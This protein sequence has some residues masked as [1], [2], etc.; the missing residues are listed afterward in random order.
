MR[1]RSAAFLSVLLLRPLL[2]AAT[3]AVGPRPYF[4]TFEQTF[5]IE[6][7][8]SSDARAARLK[9]LPLLNGKEWAVTCRWD[10][11]SLSGGLPMRDEMEKHGMKGSFYLNGPEKRA[12]GWDTDKAA[13]LL[14]GGNSLGGHGWTHAYAGWLSRHAMFE[15]LALPKLYWESVT[16]TPVCSHAFAYGN[17][18]NSFD[19]DGSARDVDE[20]LFRVGFYEF[21]GTR[22]S[23]RN[24]PSS[25]IIDPAD[26][27]GEPE[28]RQKNIETLKADKALQESNPCMTFGVHAW[29]FYG[30]TEKAGRSFALVENGL[31]YWFCNQ[32]E[33]GAYRLQYVNTEFKTEISGSAL[34][35]I[36]KRPALF[37]LMHNIPLSFEIAGTPDGAVKGIDAGTAAVEL[38]GNRFNLYYPDSQQTPAKIG[39]VANDSNC[40]AVTGRKADP[41]FS[42]LAGLLVKEDGR[43]RLTLDNKESAPLRRVRLTIRLP[44]AYTNGFQVVPVGD[45]EA[46]GT[47]EYSLPLRPST[48]DFRYRS[49]YGFFVIQADFM[50][51]EV[52]GRLYF[53]CRALD[54]AN[55]SSYPAHGFMRLGP[56]PADEV[57]DRKQ[58]AAIATGEKD[59]YALTN[60]T[61]LVFGPNNPAP[62]TGSEVRAA[63]SLYAA[64]ALDPETVVLTGIPSSQRAGIYLLRSCVESE[65]RKSAQINEVK[66]SRINKTVFLNGKKVF[67]TGKESAPGVLKAGP[68]SLLIV[69]ETGTGK[70]PV[71]PEAAAFFFRLT[72]DGERLTHIKYN[73]AQ[74]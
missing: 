7:A 13:E 69:A 36:L 35:V 51:A 16:D 14:K 23:E 73:P 3:A 37:D 43:L 39:W 11:N 8:S 47:L 53:S 21:A 26:G 59:F 25:T 17:D 70:L 1:Y 56:I 5:T 63:I 57:P 40:T 74:D 33:Y 41:D 10:D 32:A 27:G 55:D 71:N 12:F 45:I 66:K 29:S 31:E 4:D 42:G 48:E 19:P 44:L 52:P 34:K 60:G 61:R 9:I 2:Y 65:K 15:E 67:E 22:S 38:N 72:A 6:F 24:I 68:N 49:G 58:I 50:Q 18:G 28:E 46:G 30:K 20:A 62:L 64:D 54:T